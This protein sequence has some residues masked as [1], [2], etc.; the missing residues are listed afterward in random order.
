[1]KLLY[2]YAIIFNHLQYLGR[3]P[4]QSM[5]ITSEKYNHLEIILHAD[6]RRYD[7]WTR[8]WQFSIKY[9]SYVGIGI[10]LVDISKRKIEKNRIR[11]PIHFIKHDISSHNKPHCAPKIKAQIVGAKRERREELVK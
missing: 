11:Q 5:L 6:Y 4:G 7:K 1:M 3:D 2:S 9:T 10:H 8:A